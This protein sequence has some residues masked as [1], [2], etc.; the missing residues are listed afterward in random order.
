MVLKFAIGRS[1]FKTL[2]HEGFYYAD[3]TNF[4]ERL[5]SVGAPYI[6]FLRPRRFG[7]TL[8]ISTLENYYG[9]HHKEDFERTFGHL[10]IG[11]NPTPRASQFLIL[12]FNFSQIATRTSE[13]TLLDFTRMVQRGITRFFRDYRELF[14]ELQLKEL[15]SARNPAGLLSNLY[16]TIDLYRTQYTIY[17]LIDEYD[18]F[19]NEVLA[20][21]RDEFKEIVSQNGWVRKFYEAIKVGT[22]QDIIGRIF[23]TGV[24]PITLDSMT[25][26]FNIATNISHWPHFQDLM[27]FTEE[28]VTYILHQIGIAADQ[29]EEVLS[30]VKAWYNGYRFSTQAKI[31]LYNPNMVLSFANY[32]Q[33]H[34]QLPAHKLDVNI[35]SDSKK[36]QQILDANPEISF[37]IFNKLL[38]IGEIEAFHKEIFNLEAEID[39]RYLV[40]LLYYMGF[41]TIK[42]TLGGLYIYQIPNLV[43][44]KLYFDIF[45]QR[46]LTGA[47]L[48]RR[49][50]QIYRLVRELALGNVRALTEEAETILQQLSNRDALGFDEKYIK[51]TLVAIIYQLETYLIHSE[52]PVGKGYA[53]LLLIPDRQYTD[54]PRFVFEL[55][56]LKKKDATKLEEVAAAARTQLLTYLSHPSLQHMDQLNAWV[57]VFVGAEA[58]VVEK[59]ELG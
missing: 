18:H 58:K 27:G 42:H 44:Q 40:N 32:Y 36:I 34:Q 15:L 57:I 16:D 19:A 35:A 3:R 49:H 13:G 2:V 25:S 8:W 21:R 10:Y 43:I 7:K 26:G 38:K 47:N 11:Q 30:D 45:Y 28:E 33:T 46:V 6:Y 22:E 5:E 50:E 23:M 1:T 39:R 24:S 14:P 55:K 41:L 48:P 51:T 9:L 31:K 17:L 4:I 54:F 52:Y 59:I 29:F 12:K 56:Y 37:P 20:F 53:D